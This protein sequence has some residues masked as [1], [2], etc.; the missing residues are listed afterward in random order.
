MGSAKYLVYFIIITKDIEKKKRRASINP[1]LYTILY[2]LQF[3]HTLSSSH[4]Q[5]KDVRMNFLRAARLELDANL[6]DLII[7]TYLGLEKF[8]EATPLYTNLD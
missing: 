2:Y 1:I 8:E 6:S 7:Y 5:F 3:P 4:S